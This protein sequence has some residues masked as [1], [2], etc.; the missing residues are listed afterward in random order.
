[1]SDSFQVYL[2]PESLPTHATTVEGPT[3]LLYNVI[4]T[5]SFKQT[6]HHP[7]QG[8]D[9]VNLFVRHAVSATGRLD[10]ASHGLATTRRAAKKR[11]PQA[12]KG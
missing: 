9:C 8:K 3:H 2:L 1:M 7:I 11:F 4:Y 10:E 12:L 5:K 6:L